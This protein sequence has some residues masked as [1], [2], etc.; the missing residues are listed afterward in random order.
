MSNSWRKAS[1]PDPGTNRGG[2]AVIGVLDASKAA[3]NGEPGPYQ[4]GTTLSRSVMSSPT[5]PFT[6]YVPLPDN[7]T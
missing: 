2:V 4:K 3:P 6:S 5:A 7:R 1:H